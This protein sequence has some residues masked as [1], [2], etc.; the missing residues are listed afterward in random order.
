M[1]IDEEGAEMNMK[2]EKITGINEMKLGKTLI[3]SKIFLSLLAHKHWNA[4]PPK[5]SRDLSV[6]LDFNTN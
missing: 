5:Y 2:K 4:G 3:V 1:E 6:G